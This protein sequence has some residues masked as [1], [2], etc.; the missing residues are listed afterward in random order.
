MALLVSARAALLQV[1]EA[2]P[3]YGLDLIER[4]KQRT[5]GA[6][7]LLQG[8]VYPALLR[9]E[10][11]G[12]I[13]SYT[14]E[15]REPQSGGRPRVYYRITPAG[16]AEAKRDRRAVHGLYVHPSPTPSRGDR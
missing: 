14:G 1:L 10:K 15:Q 12:L 13:E 7:V 3:G 5:K 2:R 6:V 9:L 11:E 8:T 16:R 4:V